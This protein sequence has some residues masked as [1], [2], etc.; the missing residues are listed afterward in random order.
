MAARFPRG[1][2][3]VTLT[4]TLQTFI[5]LDHLG[6]FIFFTCRISGIL[7]QW[8][9]MF[10]LDICETCQNDISQSHEAANTKVPP[11]CLQFAMG[12]RRGGGGGG[13]LVIMKL[14]RKD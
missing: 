8:K 4:V 11:L 5:W 12:G 1:K 10:R 7:P 9:V 14:S 2:Q 13:E 3:P 6:V